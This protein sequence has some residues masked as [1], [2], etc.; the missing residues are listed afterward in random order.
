MHLS[1][2]RWGNWQNII[3][4]LPTTRWRKSLN[5]N[6]IQY[7]KRYVFCHR[8]IQETRAALKMIS[9]PTL[10]AISLKVVRMN[11]IGCFVSQWRRYLLFIYP[12]LFFYNIFTVYCERCVRLT[13]KGNRIRVL[14]FSYPNS[15]YKCNGVYDTANAMIG[16]V[17]RYWRS[18]WDAGNAIRDTSMFVSAGVDIDNLASKSI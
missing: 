6:P 14:I 16:Q 13:K 2:S 10:G 3:V 9:L 7:T 8:V 5:Q 17:I 4:H 18:L 1:R 11:L 15:K 12:Y